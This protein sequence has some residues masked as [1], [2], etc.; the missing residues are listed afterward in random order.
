MRKLHVIEEEDYLTPQP[1]EGLYVAAFFSEETNQ[2]IS[3]YLTTNN[4]PNPVAGASLHTT[5]VYSK[6]PVEG[7]EPQHS[8][9]IPVNTTYSKL[10]V[11]ETQT[12]TNCLVWSFFSPYLHIRFEE[13]MAAGA[14]YDFD[15]YKPH[16]TLSYDIGDF[17]WR[18]LPKPT[19]PI[20]IAGEYAESLDLGDA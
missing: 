17:D 1:Q 6:V 13:A 18:L 2:A 9:E 10:E 16:I 12:G 15:E 3:D 11:W 5:I 20:V 7:Y 19:F 8:L 4:I 14:T